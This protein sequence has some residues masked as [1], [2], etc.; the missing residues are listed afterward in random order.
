MKNLLLLF[1]FFALPASAETFT[2]APGQ[3]LDSFARSIQLRA[4]RMANGANREVCGAFV[5]QGDQWSITLSEGDSNV[6][7]EVRAEEPF[8]TFHVH[9][10]FA[11][12]SF[13]PRDYQWPGYMS[14]KGRLCYQEGIGKEAQVTRYG[15]K[16]AGTCAASASLIT[17][18]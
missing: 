3:D 11:G 4:E 16:G 7:C 15:R 2:S 1:A 8:V 13:S 10:D 5:K 18:P 12:S 14:H 17:S 9:L 6:H